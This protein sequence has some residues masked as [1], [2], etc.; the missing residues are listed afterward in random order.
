[1]QW[2]RWGSFLEFTSPFTW[3]PAHIPLQQFW[4]A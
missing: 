4:R 1:V 2:V 3:D